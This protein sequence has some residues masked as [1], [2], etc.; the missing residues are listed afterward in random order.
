MR[1]NWRRIFTQYRVDFIE[2]GPNVK[3]G[4]IN[5]KCPFCGRA[6]PSYHLGIE[7]ESGAWACWRNSRHR[8]RSPIRLLVQLLHVSP[9][10]AAELAGLDVKT[11]EVDAF[12]RVRE[13][14]LYSPDVAGEEQRRD[15]RY[16][17]EFKPVT[18]RGLQARFYAYLQTRGFADVEGLV[19]DFDLRCALTGDFKGRVIIPFFLHGELVTWTAR[20]IGNSELRYRDLSPKE[21]VVSVK[22]TLFNHDR[23]LEGG[24]VLL[25]V[26]GP[27]DVM[28]LDFYGS[29]FG[30]HAVGFSTTSIRDSQ[31]EQLLFLSSLYRRVYVMLDESRGLGR[32]DSMRLA[33]ELKFLPT[34]ATLAV[35]EGLKD[36]GEMSQQQVERFCHN[37][38]GNH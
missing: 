11:V 18:S 17:A 25:A 34:L 21:S 4:E 23:A 31:K 5:I 20:A 37:I 29:R 14:L 1:L 7:P 19:D 6:D 33:S 10:K 28:K 2:A 35:P 22:D 15:L 12:S 13:R 32:A 38:V 26:E 36:A 8:G 3:R 16:F 30:V 24:E 9:A 27:M